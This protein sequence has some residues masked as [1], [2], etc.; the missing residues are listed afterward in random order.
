MCY[1]FSHDDGKSSVGFRSS[2]EVGAVC[3]HA[4]W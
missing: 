3:V 1:A 2:E 4:A